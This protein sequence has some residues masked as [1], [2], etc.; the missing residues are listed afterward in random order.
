M[1]L[2]NKVLELCD[3]INTLDDEE[4]FESEQR[5]WATTKAR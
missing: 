5:K 1:D 2:D 3:W 4:L